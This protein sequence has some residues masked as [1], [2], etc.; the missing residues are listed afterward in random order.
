MVAIRCA[1]GDT[2]LYPVAQL[3]LKGAGLSLCL[4]AAVSKSL[5]VSILLGTVIAEMCQLLSK[6]LTHAPLEDCMI[7]VTLTQAVWQL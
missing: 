5:L 1:H 3:G 2:V 6:S 4:K 7:L